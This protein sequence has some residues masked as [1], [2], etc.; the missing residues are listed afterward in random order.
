MPPMQPKRRPPGADTE[1]TDHLTEDFF[2]RL[3]AD[4]LQRIGQP[5]PL[6]PTAPEAP[7]LARLLD[8]LPG[9]VSYLDTGLRC[10]YHSRQHAVLVGMAPEPGA[11]LHEIFPPAVI[12]ALLPCLGPALGGLPQAFE[13]TLP[14]P[15]RGQL[16]LAGQLVPDHQGDQVRGLTCHLQDITAHRLVERELRELHQE[17]QARER[18]QSSQLLA[19]EQRFRLMLDGIRDV[20]IFFLDNHGAI[21]DWT[22]SAQRLLGHS[23][24]EALGQGTECFAPPDERVSVAEDTQHALERAALLGQCEIAGWRQRRDGGL[25]WAQ[26]VITALHDEDSGQ[27]RGHSCLVRDMTEVKRLED[28]LRQLNQDL[29][30]RVQER[31]RQL[32]DINQDLESFSYSVSHD[33]RA[34][35][36]H[37]TSFVELLQEHLGDQADATTRRHLG[38]LSTAARHMGQLIEGLLAF[39]R[40]GR[41]SLKRRRVAMGALLTASVNRLQHDAQL[42]PEG[43]R[44]EWSIA[45]DPPVVAGDG[46]LL[47]QVW[48]NLI[49]NALKY[50]RQRD[51]AQIGIGWAS[52]PLPPGLASPL[53]DP[54]SPP[55]AQDGWLFWVSDN[56][57][58][59]D[60]QHAH[61]LFGVF[62]RLHKS[63]E[64]E[65]TGIGLALC[66][67]IVERHDGL[68]WA[69]G[70][71]G[72]GCT[73]RFWLPQA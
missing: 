8:Q 27:T 16:H 31:T 71:P 59:F 21:S 34:P 4:P 38:T 48:D 42:V 24:H 23:A 11:G 43:R 32:E 33:L 36:R 1:T 25:F 55:P 44:I 18:D 19:S 13:A 17:L 52:A 60:P 5:D 9:G 14:H 3:Y 72:E 56:G 2:A 22:T 40:L 70:R 10:R 65:G 57:V 39:S 28:L 20:A 62:Q 66:R 61:K 53:N 41:A 35:L 54:Q 46:L 29:E 63:S 51:T 64:F 45:A 26:M 68:I 37:I 6:A 73:V 67:R 47:S 15:Q 58:G 50:S 12:D 69:E 7:F 49:G 30:K